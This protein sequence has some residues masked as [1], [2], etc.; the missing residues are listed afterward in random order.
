MRT[1]ARL[2][3]LA[4][5]LL[6]SACGITRPTITQLVLSEPP[7]WMV[8]EPLQYRSD[9]GRYMIEVPAGFV[10]D[11]ASIPKGLWWWQSPQERTAAPAIIHDYLYWEQSCEKD[12]ADAMMYLAM[13]KLQV[14]GIPLIYA[15]IRTPFAVASF[16]KNKEA[17][18][19]GE[20]R[21]FTKEHVARLKKSF[22]DPNATWVTVQ[23]EAAAVRGLYRPLLPNPKVK[24][25]CVAALAQF[26]KSRTRLLVPDDL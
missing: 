6:L 24:Q 18:A 3:V 8:G 26:Q 2:L 14:K 1:V 13:E 19:K 17:R 5:A 21:F 20:T 7:L 10:T 25:A 23:A 22:L 16:A 11:L 12:E 9:D 15:G 4:L